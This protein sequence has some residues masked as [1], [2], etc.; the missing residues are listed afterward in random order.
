[1]N[2]N[3]NTVCVYYAVKKDIYYCKELHNYQYYQ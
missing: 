1:M 3:Y 2:N